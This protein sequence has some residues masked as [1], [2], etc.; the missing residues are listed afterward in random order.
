MI[1]LRSKRDEAA[2]NTT[3]QSTPSSSRK[4]GHVTNN[5]AA[6]GESDG[7][8]SEDAADEHSAS[9]KCRLE[10]KGAF[11]C[12]ENLPGELRSQLLSST[13][14]LPTLRPLVHASPTLHGQYRRDRNNVLR[15]RLDHE[16][17][18]FLVDAYARLM[19]RVRELGSPR[20]DEKTTGLLDT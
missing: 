13:S 5:D 8:C 1:P 16:L 10:T 17:D 14:D 4:G 12:L 18:G 9:N 20:T 15:V 3:T 6:A 19:S 7:S 2:K 11:P